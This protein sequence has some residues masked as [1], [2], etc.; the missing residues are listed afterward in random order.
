VEVG[1]SVSVVSK[2]VDSVGTTAPASS[3]KRYSPR[4]AW[5]ASLG[6]P[7]LRNT[8]TMPSV[9]TS[10]APSA[11]STLRVRREPMQVQACAG[12]AAN[13]T[14]RAPICASPSAARASL[15]RAWR[16]CAAT[17]QLR[18]IV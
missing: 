4:R 7:P 16:E 15:E 6:Q 2:S 3:T 18:I 14:A 12:R 8:R 10:R 5:R 9:G 13:S 17:L 1:V 11:G